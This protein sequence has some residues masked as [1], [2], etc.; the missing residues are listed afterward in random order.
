MEP[1]NDEVED[2]SI[3]DLTEVDIRHANGSKENKISKLT[4]HLHNLQKN[5]EQ[6]CTS[7]RKNE[8]PKQ[9]LQNTCEKLC[10]DIKT[11]LNT[12]SCFDNNQNKGRNIRCMLV[13]DIHFMI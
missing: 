4:R 12:A 13:T 11:A 9:K 6:E 10:S 3:P 8:G 7:D 5:E 2:G 1:C